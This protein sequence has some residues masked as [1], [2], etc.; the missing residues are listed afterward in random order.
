MRF[1]ALRYRRI[2]NEHERKTSFT[3]DRAPIRTYEKSVIVDDDN[4]V[5]GIRG[6]I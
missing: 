5:Y 1:R 2:S 3:L 4:R 6:Q